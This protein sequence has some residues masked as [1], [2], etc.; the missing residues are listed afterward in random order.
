MATVGADIKK[1][2]RKKLYTWN[3]IKRNTEKRVF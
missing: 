1:E 2:K 3:F